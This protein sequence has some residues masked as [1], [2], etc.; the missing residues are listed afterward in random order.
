[1]MEL[2]SWWLGSLKIACYVVLTL[3]VVEA[4]VLLISDTL[5]SN[6]VVNS[7]Q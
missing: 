7:N 4:S 3:A 6:K 5:A 1:M 2:T